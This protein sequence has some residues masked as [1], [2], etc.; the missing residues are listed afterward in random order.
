MRQKKIEMWPASKP[1]EVFQRQRLLTLQL[2]P[3][4]PREGLKKNENKVLLNNLKSV[5]FINSCKLQI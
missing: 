4:F 2:S 1:F 5:I 3:R